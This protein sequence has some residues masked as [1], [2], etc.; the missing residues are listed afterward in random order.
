[1]KPITDRLSPTITSLVIATVTVALFYIVVTPIRGFVA[2][3]LALNVAAFLGPE[4]WQI[5][6]SL[7]VHL[8]PLSAFF[9]LLGIWFVGAT[10]ERELGRRRFLILFFVPALVANLV[11]AA[12]LALAVPGPQTFAGSGMAVLG[13]FVAFGKLYGRTPVRVFGGLVLEARTLAMILVGFAVFAN[14]L[15]GPNLVGLLGDLVAIGLAFGLT[16]GRG[17]GFDDL[18]RGMG[19]PKRHL[20]VMSGGQRPGNGPRSKEVRRPSDLN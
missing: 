18:F 19:K 9:N 1:M 6:T 14:L 7:F 10:I 17:T 3:H 16:G 2:S 4:P 13:L 20:G 8:D 5:V 15:A 12:G 11:V